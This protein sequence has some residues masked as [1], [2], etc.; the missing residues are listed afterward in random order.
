MSLPMITPV[1]ANTINNLNPDAGIL[2]RDVDISSAS[3]AAT[4]MTLITSED[5]QKKWIGATKGGVNVQENRAS[6]V[7]E[8]DGSGRIPYKGERRFSGSAPKI[9]GSLVEFSPA[10]VKLV[11]GA[12]KRTGEGTAKEGVQPLADYR[13]EDYID[14]LFY[15]TNNGPDGLYVVELDNAL[16]ISGMNSQTTDKNIG[17]M[18]FEFAAHSKSPVFTQ[19][20][21]M[22]YW[23]Y[24]VDEAAAA[25][26][27]ERVANEGQQ[28]AYDPETE[29][30]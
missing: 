29:E 5:A 30:A 20:L 13:D 16:C 2:L 4:L 3:D 19:E 1:T 21:P 15:I 18:P 8:F 17:T 23:F 12:A 24:G 22:R 9:T 26:V 25:A 14:K 7:P 10:T 6:W 28:A 11:S 27:A